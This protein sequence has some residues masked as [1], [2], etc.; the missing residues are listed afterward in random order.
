MY[1]FPVLVLGEGGGGVVDY[2]FVGVD[3]RE[4]HADAVGEAETFVDYGCEV[5]EIFEVDE[6]GGDVGVGDGGAE[7]VF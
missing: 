7:L 2:G 4:T 3:A 6:G 1:V 5:G